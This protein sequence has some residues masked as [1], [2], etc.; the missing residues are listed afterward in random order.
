MQ[1][2]ARTPRDMKA[3]KGTEDRAR[4]TLNQ[5]SAPR[6]RWIQNEDAV[7]RKRTQHNAIQKKLVSSKCRPKSDSLESLA[8]KQRK[9]KKQER[10]AVSVI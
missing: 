9:E 2:V 1:L 4:G 7:L 6:G 8:L 5:G 3:K 10:M